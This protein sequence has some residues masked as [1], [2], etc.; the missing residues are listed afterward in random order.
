MALVKF[1]RGNKS[2]LSPVVS[3]GK[4]YVVVDTQEMFIDVD[5]SNRIKISDI[6]LVDNEDSLPLAPLDKFYYAQQE[7]KLFKYQ[8][9][10]WVE[11]GG[12]TDYNSLNNRPSIG[13]IVLE[14]SLSAEDLG[15]QPAGDYLTSESLD[16]NHIAFWSDDDLVT[17]KEI[18]IEDNP[19][20]Y[21]RNLA[22]TWNAV[23]SVGTNAYNLALV[24]TNVSVNLNYFTLRFIAPENYQEGFSFIFDGV[25]YTADSAAFETN[26]VVLLNFNKNNNKCYFSAGTGGSNS[27][28]DITITSQ[29]NWSASNV[30]GAITELQTS[31]TETKESITSL[32]STIEEVK[33]SI[34]PAYVV[35]STAPSNTRQLWVDTSS[36]PNVLKYYNGSAWVGVVGN[37]G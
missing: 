13:G 25:T 1:E 22:G 33:N 11:I 15:L 4:I 5:N 21:W 34:I 8:N 9:G 32:Q 23:C 2:A 20:T 3:D 37:W 28:E 7:A 30:Q 18:T 10:D 17:K 19:L 27:A 35:Q 12:V 31:V 6:I 29:G 14:G 36:T 24:D 26:Q 16:V